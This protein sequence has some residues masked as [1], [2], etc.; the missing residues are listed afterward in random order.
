M[1]YEKK[2]KKKKGEIV[3]DLENAFDNCQDLLNQ[4]DFSVNS[5]NF[6]NGRNDDDFII[7]Q[8]LGRE[9][10]SVKIIF[11]INFWLEFEFVN[12]DFI[13]IYEFYKKEKQILVENIKYSQ[14]KGSLLNEKVNSLLNYIFPSAGASIINK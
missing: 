3:F 12:N 9:Q 13:I 4:L 6:Q 14:L 1:V 5:I 2:Y 8:L 7:I 10:S 11:W